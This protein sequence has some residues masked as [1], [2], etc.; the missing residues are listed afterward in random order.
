[1]KIN[2]KQR[3]MWVQSITPKQLLSKQQNCDRLHRSTLNRQQDQNNAFALKPASSSPIKLLLSSNIQ[4]CVSSSSQENI[5]NPAFSLSVN[6]QQT[7]S[8]QCEI[9][10]YGIT[11]SL[12]LFIASAQSGQIFYLTALKPRKIDLKQTLPSGFF[13]SHNLKP[14][15][16]V[17]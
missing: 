1:M 2:L 9:L 14:A 15:N 7:T 6:L 10:L 17:L 12:Q 5:H 16:A 11:L 13:R 8:K 3:R 4:L